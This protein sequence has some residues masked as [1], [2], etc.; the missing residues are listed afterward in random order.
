MKDDHLFCT[1]ARHTMKDEV[2]IKWIQENTETKVTVNFLKVIKSIKR[3]HSN[4]L[5]R[6]TNACMA[7]GKFKDKEIFL[8]ELF[9]CLKSDD[10]ISKGCSREPLCKLISKQASL[11]LKSESPMTSS[12]EKVKL[13]F[14]EENEE[15]NEL[16]N[17]K[18]DRE[19]LEYKGF[20][21]IGKPFA[22]KLK[23][24]AQNDGFPKQKDTSELSNVPKFKVVND[25]EQINA[26]SIEENNK[27]KSVYKSKVNDNEFIIQDKKWYSQ[28]ESDV[29]YDI[30]NNLKEKLVRLSDQ[31]LNGKI[32]ITSISLS[33]RRELIPPFLLQYNDEAG[34]MAIIGSMDDLQLMNKGLINPIR[35]PESEFCMNAKKGSKIVSL[36]RVYYDRKVRSRQTAKL[37]ESSMGNVL[38]IEDKD[39]ILDLKD[40]NSIKQFKD[41]SQ[42]FE[43]IQESRK[44]LPVY[45][46]KSQLLQ[47][48]RE[49]QVTIIIGETGSGKTTQISQFLY[50]DGFCKNGK[51]IGC[52]QPRRV[53]AISVSKRVSE[54]MGVELGEEVGYSIRFEDKTSPNTKIKFMTDG[55]LLRE[56]IMDESLD[57]YSCIIMDEAHERSLN[58]DVLLGIFKRL[59]FRRMD[60]K[61][62]VTSATMNANKFSRFFGDAPQFTIPGRTFPVQVIYSRYPVTD[63]VEATVAQAIEIHLTT[64]VENGD[65]LIFMTGQEDV[66]ATCAYLKEKL[67]DIYTKKHKLVSDND[68]NDIVILPIYSSLPA[69]IQSRIFQKFDSNVRKVVVATNIAETSLTVDGIKYVIDCGYSKL[70]V[71]NPRIG[72]DS[73]NITPISLANADQRSGR[74]GRTGPGIAYRLYT[75]RSAKYDM[76]VQTIPEIQRTNLANTLLLLK[77]LNITNL[78]NFSFIDPPPTQNL[79]TSLFEL[80]TIGALDNFGNLTTLGREMSKFPLQPSLS[81]ILLLSIT[82]K[83]SEEMLIIVSMLSVPQIFYRPK[84]RQD[85]SDQAKSRFLVAESDHLTFLNI[86]SQWKAN[87]YSA[88]WC[89]KHFLQYKS[90][91]KARDI[92]DQLLKV[93]ENQHI[94]VSSS[95]VDWD[96]IRKCICSGYIHQAAKMSGLG[97]YV[98]LKNGMDVRLHPTSALFG[99]GNLP[100]YVVY[101][102][103]ILTSK[104]YISIVTVVDPLWLIEYGGLFYNVKC[105]R[106]E[107][108]Y[109]FCQSHYNKDDDGDLSLILEGLLK[110]KQYLL[111]K[112]KNDKNQFKR[113]TCKEYNS[114][115]KKNAQPV[116]NIGFKK[117]RP[118]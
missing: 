93:L 83:C 99:M 25:N 43:D 106:P 110:Y 78:L 65:I 102:E 7:L 62:I 86:Y 29:Y 91:V 64:S 32:Q 100:A 53:A 89:N 55:I 73:L 105:I 14:N 51:I 85:E 107:E 44:N 113:I 28:S 48:I 30:M 82:H 68:I 34:E 118:L 3:I 81:K 88:H 96:I 111:D 104:E 94:T 38:G 31:E 54:E 16:I 41:N 8:N 35:N 69:E 115:R 108:E 47:S 18:C 45:Q 27:I 39:D 22:E 97:K 15:Y 90:L 33:Q 67:L 23:K 112:L 95:G 46:V 50:E 57:K 40:D 63:Y 80:W 72:L 13:C 87:K 70:K 12:K 103:L 19:L 98:H 42:N 21:K 56:I 52:T 66:E 117:R 10:S 20:K 92:R 2:L 24:Y 58:T 4:D 109:G 49:N 101:H 6:F 5:S 74:A 116:V 75:E 61:L 84:E 77:S 79:M 71:Y 76:Y 59:L 11:R 9:N 36:R 37:S 114:K 17:Y 1:C 26:L 60:L